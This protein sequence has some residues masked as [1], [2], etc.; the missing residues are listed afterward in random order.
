LIVLN[1]N[2]FLSV[3]LFALDADQPEKIT[4]ILCDQPKELEKNCFGWW[5][6][7]WYDLISEHGK[8]FCWHKPNLVL[9]LDFRNSGEELVINNLSQLLASK[10]LADVHFI[11]QGK[12]ISAHKAILASASPV[13]KA[14]FL[15]NTFLKGIS[16]TIEISDV[17][18][19]VF[20]HLLDFMYSGKV[21]I[22]EVSDP[23]IEW[24]LIA[25]MKYE[26]Q[27]LK[28]LC[29]EV[30]VQRV[31]PE[32]AVPYLRIAHLSFA[33]KLMQASLEC[34]DNNRQCIWSA[35][36]WND[37]MKEHPHLFFEISRRKAV[38]H[39]LQP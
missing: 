7:S 28:D 31:C 25:A 37:L 10:L 13:M 14:M 17:S 36:E 8:C 29:E 24:L 16:Q 11:V 2:K 5:R 1:L 39:T 20:K 21:P 12:K 18:F 32:N 26:I 3:F 38:N 6:K 22:T 9:T 4:A 19:E 34:I 33:H 23:L 30:L 35:Q 15:D 27:S